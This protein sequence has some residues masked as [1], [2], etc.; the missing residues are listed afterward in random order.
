MEFSDSIVPGIFL[1]WLRQY[2]VLVK[3]LLHGVNRQNF[4]FPSRMQTPLCIHLYKPSQQSSTRQEVSSSLNKQDFEYH[5]TDTYL[6]TTT[7][8]EPILPLKSILTLLSHLYL[9]LP[10]FFSSAFQNKILCVFLA[11]ATCS[12]HWAIPPSSMSLL[13]F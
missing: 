5:G 9:N 1:D 7:K 2:E 8:I 13:F 6:E 12:T 3:S 4:Q 10:R 11:S